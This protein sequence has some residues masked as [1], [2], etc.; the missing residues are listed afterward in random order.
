MLK[1]N[2][3]SLLCDMIIQTAVNTLKIIISLKFETVQYFNATVSLQVIIGKK[4]KWKR[5]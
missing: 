1:W 4:D 2:C 3:Y 5:N